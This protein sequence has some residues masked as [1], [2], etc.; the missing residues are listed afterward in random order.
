MQGVRPEQ[1]LLCATLTAP[2]FVREEDPKLLK[3]N[4]EVQQKTGGMKAEDQ[5]EGSI[6]L[7]S[8]CFKM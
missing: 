3:P 2:L 1:G 8:V 4:G 6:H 5:K 7:N